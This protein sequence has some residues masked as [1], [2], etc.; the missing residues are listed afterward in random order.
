MWLAVLI[1]LVLG[2]VIIPVVNWLIE[3]PQ[4]LRTIALVGLIAWPFRSFYVWLFKG[5]KEERRTSGYLSAFTSLSNI[6]YQLR[7][8]ESWF[9]REK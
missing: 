5:N 1:G 9:R 3:G 6:L 4:G 2:I 8:N 7:T